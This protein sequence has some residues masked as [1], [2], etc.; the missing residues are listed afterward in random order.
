MGSGPCAGLRSP[1]LKP[2]H[3]WAKAGAA[4]K[5]AG[6]LAAD[7]KADHYF[8]GGATLV[9]VG[10]DQHLLIASADAVALRYRQA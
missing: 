10:T 5:A 1:G 8:A 7:G 9:G 3:Q 4:G 2:A 6:V